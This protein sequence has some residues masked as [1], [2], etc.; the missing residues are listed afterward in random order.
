MPTTK[1]R[2]FAACNPAD[3][4]RWAQMGGR[5]V[6]EQGAGRQW[7]HEQARAAGRKGGL[8]LREKWRR[9]REEAGR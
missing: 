2:G 7:T 6:H 9:A 4:R 1:K 5:A 3:V 8:A